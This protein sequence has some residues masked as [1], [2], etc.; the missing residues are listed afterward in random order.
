MLSAEP[1]APPGATRRSLNLPGR[2]VELSLLE[3]GEP[4]RPLALLHHANGFCAAQ[5]AEVAEVLQR[6]FHVVALD[7]RGHGH[8]PIPAA[9]VT[10]ETLGWGVMRDD[11]IAVG[12]AL[13]AEQGQAQIALALGHS[14]GGTLGLA[15][16]AA[17]PTRYRAVLALD[18]VILPPRIPG[19][20]RGNE[21]GALARRRRAVFE[22]RAAARASFE[23]KPFFA[24]WSER[25]L[26]LY[27]DYA[28]GATPSGELAL[29][30]PPEVEATVFES[31]IAFDIVDE[32]VA[33]EAH[34]GVVW[35][36]HGHF[37]REIH[38][39]VV[40]ALRHGWLEEADAGHLMLMQDPALVLRAVGRLLGE[41]GAFA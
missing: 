10:P 30:C 7:A 13:L 38:A 17:V 5:W 14:F 29:R 8:S 28:L 2:G 31:S 25:A 33:I 3:W 27:V 37:P 24:G 9:G 23:G 15:A 41:G 40:A 21:L 20:G 16:A 39:A 12:A 19:V 34:T 11:L 6:R 26:D 18:P 35:A 36:R 4:G 32:A 1:A 22:S